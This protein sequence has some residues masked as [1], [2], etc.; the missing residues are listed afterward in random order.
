MTNRRARVK[1][2]P[3]R[4]PG[5]GLGLFASADFRRGDRIVRLTGPVF[6]HE[7]ADRRAARTKRGDTYFLAVDEGVMDVRGPGQ[8]ANDAVG[9]AR[10]PGC[11][12]N[13]RFVQE[14]DGVWLVATGTIR[15]GE[16]VFVPYGRSYWS[17][18]REEFAKRWNAV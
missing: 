15:A 5:S 7:E 9:M 17:A 1:V 10:V 11:R 3:S 18:K 2:M 13:S 14:E 6:S 12:N 8:Y 4:I 16:E